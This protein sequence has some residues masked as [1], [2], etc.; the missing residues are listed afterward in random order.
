LIEHYPRLSDA[1]RFE[2]LAAL[3]KASMPFGTDHL[4]NLMREHG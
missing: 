3:R 2:A 1:A 4:L